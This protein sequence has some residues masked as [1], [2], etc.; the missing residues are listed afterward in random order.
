MLWQTTLLPE[1]S[2]RL[3]YYYVGTYGGADVFFRDTD[4]N[5]YQAAAKFG[6][7]SPT[8]AAL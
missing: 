8:A 5:V 4:F 3:D 2:E 6:H 7:L 1:G